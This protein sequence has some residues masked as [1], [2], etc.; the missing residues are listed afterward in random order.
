[1]VVSI[2]NNSKG[3]KQMNKALIIN[4]SPH[5]EGPTSAILKMI[6]ERI[7]DEYETQTV[8]AYNLSIKPCI[9]CFKCRPDGVCILPKDDGQITGEKMS[10]AGLIVVGAPVYWGNIPAPLKIIFDRNVVTFEN[11]LSGKP[12]PR[13]KGKKAVIAVTS[14]SGEKDYRKIS[15]S[16]GAIQTIR[17]VLESGGVKIIKVINVHSAW[18][19]E[20]HREKIRS[21]ISGIDFN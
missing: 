2:T 12:M 19:F 5:R 14:G 10:D 16:Y 3:V 20:K 4:G 11:F 18:D 15:Q 7:R 13:M 8:H 6:E 9:G 21:E 17:T 1:M